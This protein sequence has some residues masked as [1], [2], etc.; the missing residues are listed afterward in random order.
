MFEI[1]VWVPDNGGVSMCFPA[2][3]FTAKQVAETDAVPKDRPHFIVDR[4]SLPKDFSLSHAWVVSEKGD[5]TLDLSR[6]L[7]PTLTRTPEQKLATS[8][9]TVD[10]LKH[11]LGLPA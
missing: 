10:E 3:G 8:G 9:L 1:I 6:V 2:S 7:S 11:L 5:V 4:A